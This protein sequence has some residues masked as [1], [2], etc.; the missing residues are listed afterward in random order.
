MF[1]PSAMLKFPAVI[2]AANRANVSIYS[3]DAAGLRVE[4]GTAE[5]AR[6]LNSIAAAGMGNQARGDDRG[7]SGPYMRALERNEDLLRFDPRSGLGSLSDQ[8]GGF[9]IHDTNDLVAGMR[10]IDEDMNA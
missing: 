6:E 2:N 4:S 10:R 7:G 8:T 5:A 1:P 3:I 9:L